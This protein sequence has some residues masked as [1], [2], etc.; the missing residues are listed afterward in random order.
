MTEQVGANLT[1]TRGSSCKDADDIVFRSHGSNL[2]ALRRTA[3][4]QRM[5]E[6]STL[7]RISSTVSSGVI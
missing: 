3:Q 4:Q 1:V 6:G 2:R 7:R 5:S